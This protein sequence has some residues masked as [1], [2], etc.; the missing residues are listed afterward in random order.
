MGLTGGVDGGRPEGPRG[1][2]FARL[3][4]RWSAGMLREVRGPPLP[5]EARMDPSGH[6]G[7]VTNLPR[8]GPLAPAMD[9]V[10]EPSEPG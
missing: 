3:V 4:E 2:P 5:G 9:A 7:Q 1:P 10:G 6:G 8:Q